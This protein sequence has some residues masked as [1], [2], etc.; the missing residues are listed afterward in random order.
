VGFVAKLYIFNAAIQSDLVW[1]VIVGVLNTAVSA[2]YYL[3]I[4]RHMYLAEAPAEGDIKPGPWLATAVAITSV[5][6]VVMFFAST[7]LIDAA[8]RAVSA[9]G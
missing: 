8:Q 7:F 5:G 2:Y 4:V 6:V 1:L 3:R 9:L